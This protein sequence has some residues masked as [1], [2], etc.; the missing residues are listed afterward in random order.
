MNKNVFTFS[1]IIALILSGFLFFS[2]FGI[3]YF[4]W[5][6]I[7][8]IKDSLSSTSGFFG[9]FTTLGAAVIA[10]YLFTDWKISAKFH[11]NKEVIDTFWNTYIDVKIILVSLK[12]RAILANT[13]SPTIKA[14]LFDSISSSVTKLYYHQQKIE[15]YFN[16]TVND[17]LWSEL[18]SIFK[19][20]IKLLEFNKKVDANWIQEEKALIDRLNT[21]QPNL[22]TNLRNLNPIENI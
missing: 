9:G 17:E 7:N 18:E 14:E 19:E 15:L 3:L 13:Q 20:Y 5:G 1:V 6:D 11:Q 22:Y 2:I 10:A 8:A 21:L 16:I 4:Y 12:D